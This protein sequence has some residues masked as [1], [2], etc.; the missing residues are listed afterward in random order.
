[1]LSQLKIEVKDTP[2]S[3]PK[4]PSPSLALD[5]GGIV[6]IE[7]ATTDSQITTESVSISNC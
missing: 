2:E 4:E 6:Q 5:A 1:M 7:V 3:E